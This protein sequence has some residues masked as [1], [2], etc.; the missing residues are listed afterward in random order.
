MFI[1]KK[2]SPRSFPYWPLPL[3]LCWYSQ[4][5]FGAQVSPRADLSYPLIIEQSWVTGNDNIAH[6]SGHSLDKP[7]EYFGGNDGRDGGYE[8]DDR[9]YSLMSSAKLKF[10]QRGNEFQ[11]VQ[12][13]RGYGRKIRS[14]R[15]N[16]NDQGQIVFSDQ[17]FSTN[18]QGEEFQEFLSVDGINLKFKKKL[19]RLYFFTVAVDYQSIDDQ[20]GMSVFLQKNYHKLLAELIS[21]IVL[22]DYLDHTEIEEKFFTTI[23]FGKGFEIPISSFLRIKTAAEV[24]GQYGKEEAD[25]GLGIRL[26]LAVDSFQYASK[27][28]STPRYELKIITEQRK[29][30]NNSVEGS[31]ILTLK[32]RWWPKKD[33]VIFFEGGIERIRDRYIKKYAKK[34]YKDHG[35]PDYFHTYNLGVELLFE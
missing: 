34:E 32:K 23:S 12:Y 26:K 1:K 16:I 17:L 28:S 3:I 2:T 8:G 5:V 9:G 11:I 15:K 35:R 27:S 33:L 18:L 29:L 20:R 31:T 7:I 24:M 25:Q 14:P 30:K 10:I 19:D 6:G 21:D 4:I 22:Y 13:S